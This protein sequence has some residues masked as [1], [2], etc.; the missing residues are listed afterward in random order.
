MYNPRQV[1]VG[2][3]QFKSKIRIDKRRYWYTNDVTA[4]DEAHSVQIGQ[5]YSG[6]GTANEKQMQLHPKKVQAVMQ[7]QSQILKQTVEA[8][9]RKLQARW[10]FESAQ[11]VQAQ[12][13]I[14]VEAEL[15]AAL[16]QEITAEIQSR[17]QQSLRD[18]S[19]Y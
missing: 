14:H 2:Q 17:D 15:M 6:D 7:C 5:V 10:T 16:A 12:Q 13:G 11:D 19:G 8:K 4:G 9:T 1:P 18:P 3:I